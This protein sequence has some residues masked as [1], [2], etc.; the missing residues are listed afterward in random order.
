MLI[1]LAT[2]LPAGILATLQFIPLIRYK[3]LIVHRVCGY[4]ALLLLVM[5]AASGFALGRRSF[6]GDFSI[7]TG[8]VVL[9]ASVLVSAALAYYNIKRLQ[10][11]QH[12]K[13]MLRTWFYAGSIITLRILQIMMA[14]I[15]S[16]INQYHTVWSCNEVDFMLKNATEVAQMYPLCAT[17]Q[18]NGY[19][20]VPAIM[21]SAIGAGSSLR[22]A[23]G[24]ALWMALFI[25][26]T[27]IEIYIHLTPGEAERLRKVSYEKQLERG[28]KYP[29]SM[30]TTSDR[31][32]DN[33]GVRYRPH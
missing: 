17:N 5:G 26:A 12:R 8:V 3:A 22:F 30:G 21:T 13:W 16:D 6:G 32:G 9:G 14:K 33:F 27:G 11:D 28:A 29:G 18:Q 24:P 1:H 15:A 25:H 4:V 20:V 23:F 2:V 7:Q 19:V 31:A 10:I